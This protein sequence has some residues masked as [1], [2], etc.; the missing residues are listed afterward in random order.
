M[1]STLKAG[2]FNG[3]PSVLGIPLL[4]ILV[5]TLERV[6][7][8][9]VSIPMVEVILERVTKLSVSIPMVEEMVMVMVKRILVWFL[10]LLFGLPVMI[11]VF[12]SLR[13]P[14]NPFLIPLICM[15]YLVY[16]SC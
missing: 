15:I 14:K 3:V 1:R 2:S 4:T 9:T 7:K 13:N 5:P 16:S 8:L 10:I 11:S 6:T 12:Q